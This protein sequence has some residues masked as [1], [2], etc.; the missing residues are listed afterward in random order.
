LYRF[1]IGPLPTGWCENNRARICKGARPLAIF[2][3][4]MLLD[5]FRSLRKMGSCCRVSATCWATTEFSVLWLTGRVRSDVVCKQAAGFDC[6]RVARSQSKQPETGLVD[7][8]L[9]VVQ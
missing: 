7:A 2:L 3:A 1:W 4:E 6:A 8:G 5:N 9:A